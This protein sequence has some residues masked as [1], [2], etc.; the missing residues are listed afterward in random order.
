MSQQSHLTEQKIM[1]G[2]GSKV[3]EVGTI[4]DEG[5]CLLPWETFRSFIPSSVTNTFSWDD[6]RP[7][8][9]NTTGKGCMVLDVTEVTETLEDQNHIKIWARS[10]HL[11]EP[12]E[13]P[14]TGEDNTSMK[15]SQPANYR[16]QPKTT[17]E[18]SAGLLNWT[19]CMLFLLFKLL[20]EMRCR[21]K[22]KLIVSF[23][24]YLRFDLYD[25][26]SYCH[27]RAILKGSVHPIKHHVR[28]SRHKSMP[29]PEWKEID[30]EHVFHATQKLYKLMDG[31]VVGREPEV[32]STLKYGCTRQFGRPAIKFV[33]HYLQKWIDVDCR[34]GKLD[35]SDVPKFMVDGM[36]QSRGDWAIDEDQ[37]VDKWDWEEYKVDFQEIMQV[38]CPHARPKNIVFQLSD[39]EDAERY[40]TNVIDK[41]NSPMFSY[42]VTND[43]LPEP[44]EPQLPL[45]KCPTVIS[46]SS[47]LHWEEFEPTV[48]LCSRQK[49]RWEGK[50]SAVVTHFPVDGDIK[51]KNVYVSGNRISWKRLKFRYRITEIDTHETAMDYLIPCGVPTPVVKLKAGNELDLALEIENEPRELVEPDWEAEIDDPSKVF[52]TYKSRLYKV[53]NNAPLEFDANE[54]I[55]QIGYCLMPSYPACKRAHRKDVE[56]I[57][58][59]HI[60]GV[61]YERLDRRKKH[62]IEVVRSMGEARLDFAV[63]EMERDKDYLGHLCDRLYFDKCP[64]LTKGR[65]YPSWLNTEYDDSPEALL[66]KRDLW[67]IDSD[68]KIPALEP[69]KKRPKEDRPWK[70]DGLTEA[71]NVLS[72]DHERTLKKIEHYRSE[73]NKL[74]APLERRKRH[75]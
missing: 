24:E 8:S 13:N 43:I 44:K 61:E 25:V 69:Q 58:N 30:S 66:K 40:S 4:V 14:K 36:I 55:T 51:F 57:I 26:P 27:I 3:L 9:R 62:A 2:H 56:Y 5:C 54:R 59:R 49:Q 37:F 53:Q 7:P 67:M 64:I 42:E 74:Q 22:Y 72:E 47:T 68:K 1:S 65:P 75:E 46:D 10:V 52:V 31:Q 70:V 21:V 39:N 18:D 50:H 41:F 34:K 38:N 29:L 12:P 11:S 6:T 71:I 73:L 28:L 16:L 48:F 45:I 35:P 20:G 17:M 32:I 33:T 23:L 19:Y 63:S 60:Q 15:K